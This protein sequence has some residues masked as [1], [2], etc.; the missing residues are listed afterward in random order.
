MQKKTPIVLC[1][2]S[3]V[4]LSFLYSCSFFLFSLWIFVL[5]YY[6]NFIWLFDLFGQYS[7]RRKPALTYMPPMR[8]IGGFGEFGGQGRSQEFV[9]GDNRGGLGTE[10]PSGVQEQS[11]GGGPGAKPPEA[12]EN[13]NFQLR[14]GWACTHVPSACR[15]LVTPLSVGHSLTKFVTTVA[16]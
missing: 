6:I 11:P 7:T 14:R 5:W 4:V 1:V 16:V 15:P 2:Q 13:A 10:V 12:R 8:N 3:I 9:T